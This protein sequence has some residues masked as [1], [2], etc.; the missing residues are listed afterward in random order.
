M[1]HVQRFKARVLGRTELPHAELTPKNSS[2]R[3][4]ESS[5]SITESTKSSTTAHGL[6]LLVDSKPDEAGLMNFPVDIV[7]I[8]GLNGNA[9]STWRHQPDGTVWLRDLLPDFLPGCRVYTY[10]YP[11]KIWSQSSERIQEYALNLLVALRDVREDLNASKRSIIF[12]CHSLGGI[13]F[14]QALVAAHENDDLYGELLKSIRGVVFLA[15]PHRGSGTA[16]LASICGS[17]VNSFASAGLGPRAV[18]TDLLKTLI[19]DSDALQDLTMS[20]RNRLGNI[21]VVSFYETL[22]LSMGPLSSSLVVSPASAVLGIPY[23]EVI[24]MPEDHRTICRFPRETESYLK[25]ARALR[26]IATKSSNIGPTLKRTSTHSSNIVLSTLERTCMSLL[27]DNDVAKDVEPPPK[28]VPGTCQWIRSHSLFV[29]WLEAGTN[30]LL[31]LT[32]HPGCGKTMLSYSLAQYFDDARNKSRNVLIYLCQNK[33]KQTDARAVLIGLILQIA[34]RHRSLVRYIRSAFEK[35]GSSI[36][37]SFASLWRIFVR[38][39]KDPKSG[40][41]YV[42]VDALDECERTS[43]HQLLVSISDMLTDSSQSM[44]SDSRVKFLIT[45]RPF[46]HQSYANSQKVLQS[47]ISIDDDQTGYTEDLQTFIQERIHEISLNR[48]F[49]NDIRDFLYEAIMSKADRTFLWIHLVLASIEKSI[50]TSRKE[51]QKIIASIPEGLAEIYHR[52]L[53]AIP[54]DHQ[55]D[56]SKLLKLLLACSRPLSLVELNIAFTMESSYT[57]TEEIMQN[58]HNSIAHT[59]QGILGALVRVTGQQVSLVH[60]TVKDY[61]Q[62]RDSASIDSPPAIRMVDPQ[63]SALQLATV[64]IQ[65]LLLDDFT[66]DLFPTNDPSTVAEETDFFGELP[67]GGFEGDF[68]DQEDHDLDSGALFHDPDILNSKMCDSMALDYPFYTYAS[69][70]WAEHFAIC[71]EDAPEEL[72]DFARSLLDPDTEN[73]RNWLSFYHTKASTP[74]DDGITDQNPI[75][76]AS[77]FNS[78]TALNSLLLDS[79]PSQ[80]IKNQSLYWASR[81]GHDRIVTALLQSGAEPDVQQ[82][83]GQ[84]ALTVAAEHGN[85]S[86]IIALLADSLTNANAPGRNGRTALSFACRGGYDEIVKELLKQKA[87]NPDEPDNTGATPFIW[88]V[89]GGHHSTISNLARLRNVNIN[90]QDKTGRTAVSWASGDGMAD[91]VIRLLKL[92]CIDI[93][94]KDNK[95]RSSL[96]WAAGNGCTDVVEIL[97]A[98]PRI[99]KM[100]MDNDKR[101]A[102]SWAST[103]GHCQV[104][105]K[106]LEA[107]CP[108]VDAE[109]IDGWTPLAWAIQTDSPETVHALVSNENVLIER[110]DRGGRT[111]LSWAV[112]YGHIEVVK[113][114]LRAGADTM[115][116]T[117]S[118]RTPVMIAKDFGRDDMVKELEA[119]GP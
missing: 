13:V 8:H 29:S 25:V 26:R 24:P 73:C 104:L 114:L 33:N 28:P 61:L 109:D 36:I 51:F 11:S 42:I 96:S 1:K 9:V 80:I 62:D 97:L 14:K 57:T 72:K 91:T 89:G 95:G 55:E 44:K 21:H 43:C 4:D 37:Q 116:Q 102:I 98:N 65:Y 3:L 5:S 74:L 32:G 85:K 47:R 50:L 111:A 30:A 18:R 23:E 107:G 78:I 117:G 113:V 6:S 12:V 22:P 106:L 15:T 108:G 64:C 35:E 52:Y 19:Y 118:G 79:K 110:R 59:V 46:L 76:L 103:Q 38:I 69:L 99:D 34:D 70:H 93:N 77:Q 58:S 66:V 49:S 60:Q 39:A 100:S 67:L 83:D 7:A 119:Y 90:H 92:P 86:C 20:A 101:N 56:A 75:I 17:I 94:A 54:L 53:S 48:Q 82:L 31:W 84:T 68:W 112:E 105:V 10:G 40:P 27:S 71:E 115:T 88:A 81:L 63:G 16:N 41:L 2:P 87:C 45:S